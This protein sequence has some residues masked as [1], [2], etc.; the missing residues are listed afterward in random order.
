MT[1]RPGLS[2]VR[3]FFG[4]TWKSSVRRAVSEE[5][6]VRCHLPLRNGSAAEEDA[7]HSLRRHTIEVA[8]IVTMIKPC[9]NRLSV[10]RRYSAASAAVS[11]AG[12]TFAFKSAIVGVVFLAAA[13]GVAGVAR[14]TDGTDGT[15][16]AA[17]TN[18]VQSNHTATAGGTGGNGTAGSSSGLG[19]AG[20]AGGRGGDG[21][22]NVRAG[23]N[24]F[25]GSS[26]GAS[27]GRGGNDR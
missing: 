26:V 2:H 18:G 16:G 19:G 20:G 12:N 8:M 5:L 21:R 22:T 4:V 7:A 6:P 9:L 14:A 3:P 13:V 24:T 17:G 10:R 11:A 27:G 1:I 23:A 25:S 15:S